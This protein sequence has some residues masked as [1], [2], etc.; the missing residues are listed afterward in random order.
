MT[1]YLAI[2]TTILVITQIIRVTQN[3]INLARNNK[4][5][6][7]QLKQIGDVTDED[8]RMQK[9]AYKLLVEYF[10]KKGRKE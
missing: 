8:L 7:A 3:G 4:V 10:K 6:D 1:I 2:I 5:F 9:E